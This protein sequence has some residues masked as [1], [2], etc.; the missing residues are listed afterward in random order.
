MDVEAP[1]SV[2][3]II[4]DYDVDGVEED[5]LKVDENGNSYAESIW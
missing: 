2:D 1:P 3:V 5:I 4:R